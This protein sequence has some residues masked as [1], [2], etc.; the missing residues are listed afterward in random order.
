MTEFC[1]VYCHTHSDELSI[2]FRP[3]WD[4]FDR[5]VEKIISTI[6]AYASSVFSISI[7]KIATFDSRIW[8]GSTPYKVA[9]YF[10]WR[11]S[12]AWRNCLQGYCY[13]TLRQKYSYSPL[14]ATNMMQ[15]KGKSWLNDFLSQENININHVPPW[16]RRGTGL[17]RDLYT[18][19]GFNPQT[20]ETVYVFRTKIK[21]EENLPIRGYREFVNNLLILP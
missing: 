4:L 16:Q 10:S 18:K 15:K 13:W 20:Q 14:K 12:H 8:I 1:G 3:D 5:K 17:F 11:Q 19:E 7:K 9:D 6:A 2:A 21:I